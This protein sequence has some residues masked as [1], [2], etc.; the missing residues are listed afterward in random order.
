MKMFITI[1]HL[2][3]QQLNTTTQFFKLT[4]NVNTF[5]VLFDVYQYCGIG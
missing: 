3:F 5:I 4:K 1:F 2:N